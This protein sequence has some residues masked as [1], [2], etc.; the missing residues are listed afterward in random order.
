MNFERLP[1]G[2]RSAERFPM[3]YFRHNFEIL[4]FWHWPGVIPFDF[5]QGN[6][7]KD[8]SYQFSIKLYRKRKF[9]IVQSD[10]DKIIKPERS[11]LCFS[12]I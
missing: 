1:V 7:N 2:R 11:E 5:A 8:A 4:K 6:S 12:S 9:L 10:F 3:G